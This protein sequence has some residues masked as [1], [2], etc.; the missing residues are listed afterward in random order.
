[1]EL[2]GQLAYGIYSAGDFIGTVDIRSGDMRHADEENSSEGGME[3]YDDGLRICS[4]YC[5]I[6]RVVKM[7]DS[8]DERMCA[9][10]DE[11]MCDGNNKSLTVLG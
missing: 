9:G 11:R 6:C 10:N 4:F 5:R 3:L 2:I 8:N 1:M 7:F